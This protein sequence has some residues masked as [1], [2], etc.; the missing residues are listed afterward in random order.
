MLHR[1][2]PTRTATYLTLSDML[3][4]Q[5]LPNKAGSFTYD[6]DVIRA[7]TVD[8]AAYEPEGR[9]RSSVGRNRFHYSGSSPTAA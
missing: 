9:E 6:K 3:G 8:R 4:A 2:V 1:G 7:L 5:F